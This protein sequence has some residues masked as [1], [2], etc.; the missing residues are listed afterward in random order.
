MLVSLVNKF[1]WLLT[2]FLLPLESLGPWQ[3][4]LM[5]MAITFHLLGHGSSFICVVDELSAGV[6][7]GKDGLG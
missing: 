5:V 7:L 3:P 1:L 6:V 2:S 4:L